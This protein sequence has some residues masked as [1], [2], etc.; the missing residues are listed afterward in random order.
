MNLLGRAAVGGDLAWTSASMHR[1]QFF[2][3]ARMDYNAQ[4]VPDSGP[5]S[6][7]QDY[8]Q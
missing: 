5:D 6:Q 4:Q 3:V 8:N 1:L 7:I 2:G